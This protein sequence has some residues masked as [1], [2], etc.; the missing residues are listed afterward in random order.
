V[1]RQEALKKLLGSVGT[2][3]VIEPPFR[4]DYGCF[5]YLDDNVYMNFDCVFLDVCKITVGKNTLF[6]PGVH[7]YAA[8]HPVDPE[9]RRT[10]VICPGV[11]IGNGV[12]VAAGAVVTKDVPDRVVVAGVPA[13]IIKHL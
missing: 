4:C 7:V 3:C 5:I 12:T 9:V 11:T 1:Q 6:G 8:T 2:N 13:K 10:A